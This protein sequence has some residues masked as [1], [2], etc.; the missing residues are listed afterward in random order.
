MNYSD[1]ENPHSDPLVESDDM[2]R[3]PAQETAEDAVDNGATADSTDLP[4][5]IAAFGELGAEAVIFEEG[6]AHLFHRH[7]SSVKR[8][9][10][11]GELPPP[12]KLFGQGTWTV[13]AIVRHIEDRLAQAA[14]KRERLERRISQMSP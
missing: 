4:G 12:T 3:T 7:V 10:Q 14:K 9:V 6:V 1:P 2:D 8:A 11:R 5:V 13:G